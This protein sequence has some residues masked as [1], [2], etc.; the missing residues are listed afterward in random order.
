MKRDYANST[1]VKMSG[2][3][4]EITDGREQFPSALRKQDRFVQCCSKQ[5]LTSYLISDIVQSNAK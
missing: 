3:W 4:L 2:N 5:S 1:S